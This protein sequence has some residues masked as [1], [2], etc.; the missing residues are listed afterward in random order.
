MIQ[1]LKL[2]LE[3]ETG[4]SQACGVQGFLCGQNLGGFHGLM[5][6]AFLGGETAQYEL[7]AQGT[8]RRESHQAPPESGGFG[9]LMGT[10]SLPPGCVVQPSGT[11]AE[12]P[13][14]DLGVRSADNSGPE[15]VVGCALHPGRSGRRA[16][17]SSLGPGGR[18]P[19]IG[20]M[21]G[22]CSH[23]GSMQLVGVSLLHR[24]V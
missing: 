7:Q 8:D 23:C 22:T 17:G 18:G 20:R 16:G 3:F 1:N 13:G 4:P 10:G 9:A 6:P 14:N 5:G 24:R 12:R 19:G 2:L 11:L 15:E 21:G